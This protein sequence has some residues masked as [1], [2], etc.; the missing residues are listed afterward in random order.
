M[1]TTPALLSIDHDGPV[2]AESHRARFT[3]TVQPEDF[4]ALVERVNAYGGPDFWTITPA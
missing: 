1:T 4:P 2:I 3:W